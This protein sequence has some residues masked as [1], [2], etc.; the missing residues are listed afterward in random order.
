MARVFAAQSR[1]RHDAAS[2]FRSAAAILGG[3]AA[4]ELRSAMCHPGGKLSS[5]ARP[6]GAPQAKQKG[7]QTRN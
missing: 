2:L 6:Q 3:A 4:G 7:R 1:T 5:N